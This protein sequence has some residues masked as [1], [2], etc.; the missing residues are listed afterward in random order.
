MTQGL[1]LVWPM[2]L[3]WPIL[4]PP[5]PCAGRSGC[6]PVTA[7]VPSPAL[8]TLPPSPSGRVG[9]L[10]PCTSLRLKP[11]LIPTVPQLFSLPKQHIYIFM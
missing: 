10:Y 7:R 11:I 2:P 6:E 1:C 5:L 9:Q 8:Q 3:R 4:T